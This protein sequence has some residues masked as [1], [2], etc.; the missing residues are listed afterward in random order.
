MYLPVAATI[1]EQHGLITYRQ[2]VT[3]GLTSADVRRLRKA[4]RL[5]PLR[6]GVHADAEVWESLDPF[7]GQPLLRMRAAALALTCTDYVFSHDSAAIAQDMGAPQP[8]KALVHVTR[9]KVHGDAVRA[10]VKHHLAPYRP[11]D[12]VEVAGLRMLSRARTALDM[13]REHG[14]AHG[15]AACD[16]GMRHGVSREELTGVLE[17]MDCWPHSRAMRWC[18]EHATGRAESYLE[19]LARDLVLELG[20]GMPEVQF[21]LSDGGRCVWCDLR[22]RRH[23]FEVDGGVKYDD[24][25]VLGL[26]PREVLDAEKTRQD[27]ISGFKLGVSRITAHDCGPGRRQAIARLTRE[28][29]DTCRRF[30]TSVDDLAPYVVDPARRAAPGLVLPPTA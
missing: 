28:Y 24:D 1:A 13:V 15:L 18:I 29:R 14:R 20:I 2:L 25:N 6:R 12:V 5:V 3:A 10:G 16:V 23:V 30:G 19:S 7:R 26:R 8:T 22:V 21:G 17:W 27:F 11:E 4:G 9:P